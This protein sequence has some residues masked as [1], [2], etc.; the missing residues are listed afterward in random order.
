[1]ALTDPTGLCSDLTGSGGTDDCG[2]GS[3][4]GGNWTGYP[5]SAENCGGGG[6]FGYGG[7]GGGSGDA[8][9]INPNPAG[10]PFTDSEWYFYCSLSPFDG[11]YGP[12][13][14]PNL[15]LP[16]APFPASI[17]NVK[18]QMPCSV[19]ANVG[20]VAQAT[21][22]AIQAIYNNAGVGVNFVNGPAQLTVINSGF[23]VPTGAPANG[24]NFGTVSYVAGD[25]ITLAG[26]YF[27]DTQSQ[28]DTGIGTVMAHEMGHY[29]AG[30]M[31][32]GLFSCTPGG[33]MNPGGIHSPNPADWN[34]QAQDYQFNDAQKQAVQKQCLKLNS[35]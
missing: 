23:G 30:C 17:L 24:I 4:G 20:N 33:L 32:V 27:G 22:D 25:V 15:N 9:Q 13:A 12:G 35:Q 18:P 26:W 3:D 14:P 10:S 11:C 31:H 5:P 7:G 1:M 21:M 29:M 8:S 19:T 28:I 16:P 2:G 6:G 34:P